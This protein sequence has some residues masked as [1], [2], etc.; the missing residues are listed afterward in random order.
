MLVNLKFNLK[1]G[2]FT[3]E[4]TVLSGTSLYDL[5]VT[6]PLV[7]PSLTAMDLFLQRI[8]ELEPKA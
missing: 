7:N 2:T 3:L 5:E 1:E 8:A 4:K 6:L